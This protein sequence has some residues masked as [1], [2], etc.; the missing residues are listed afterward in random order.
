MKVLPSTSEILP[1]AIVVV[2]V[3]FLLKMA[4]ASVKS[5]VLG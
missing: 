2:G 3:L 1:M 4:P 5:V